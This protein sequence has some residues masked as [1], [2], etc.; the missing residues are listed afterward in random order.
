MVVPVGLLLLLLLL[1]LF[2]SDMPASD[3]ADDSRPLFDE[4]SECA[5]GEGHIEFWPTPVKPNRPEP[6]AET[7]AAAA[8]NVSRSRRSAAA[9][10]KT[11]CAANWCFGSIRICSMWVNRP[12]CAPQ[13]GGERHRAKKKR[14]KKNN[15]FIRKTKFT[16]T[17]KKKLA[18]RWDRR[19]F[20]PHEKWKWMA[21]AEEAITTT[22]K[23]IPKPMHHRISLQR[24]QTT[25]PPSASIHL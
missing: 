5:D 19:H 9:R 20:L 12:V 4:L 13:N 18:K 15:I 3:S 8:N 22:K 11:Y 1:L 10:D 25:R 7:A 17:K 16:F 14:E 23:K 2:S 24:V 6:D 21:T